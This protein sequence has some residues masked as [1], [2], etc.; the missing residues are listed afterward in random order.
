MKPTFLCMTRYAMVTL[1]LV[2]SQNMWAAPK[3]SGSP[4]VDCGSKPIRLAFYEYGVFYFTD[5]ERR[6]KGIDHDIVSELIQRSGCRFET[7]VMARARIWSDLQSGA[8]DMSVSGIQNP[9]RD[10]FA[11]FAHYAAIKNYALVRADVA[12]S[13]RS[14]ED[15]VSK[16]DL[17]FGVVRAFKHGSKQDETLALLRAQGR[18]EESADVD[19]IYRKLKDKRIHA[20]F[21]QP[22]VY[23]RLTQAHNMAALVSIQDWTPSEAGVPHG[24]IMA[25]SRFSAAQA[26]QWK[27]LVHEM[28]RDGTLK[29]IY[30]RY[31]S[32]ADAQRTLDQLAP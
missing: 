27:A 24:L 28:R 19:T 25:K 29:A 9:E 11:F 12:S 2:L 31:L 3:V 22:P 17:K 8:L 16:P 6:P 26:A 20:I 14:A 13:I 21:S 1:A 10:Q 5:S 4:K 15:F 18:V 23:Q 32:A 30:S 7:Q